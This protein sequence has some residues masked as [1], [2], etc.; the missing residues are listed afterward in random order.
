M[1][2]QGLRRPQRQG[3]A[4]SA[5]ENRPRP[6]NNPKPG[7]GV[8]LADS[9]LAKMIAETSKG[10]TATGG[11]TVSDLLDQWLERLASRG[12]SPTTLREYHRLADKIVRPELGRVK[13]PS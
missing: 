8:R 12:R 3:A 4:D 10:R 2:S 6:G 5:L 9:E 13:P 11:E 1:A 7:A